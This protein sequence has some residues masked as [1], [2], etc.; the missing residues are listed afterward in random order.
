[1][2]F[3]SDVGRFR[4]VPRVVVYCVVWYS[5]VQYVGEWC[6]RFGVG[7]MWWGNSVCRD[8]Y[9]IPDVLSPKWSDVVVS[10]V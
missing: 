3:V 8:L 10:Y 1:M 7:L 9:S 2:A 5:V 4:D 6:S